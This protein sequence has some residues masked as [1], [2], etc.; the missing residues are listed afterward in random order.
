MRNSLYLHEEFLLLALKE[1]AGT[2]ATSESIEYPLATAVISELMLQKRI[3]IDEASGKKQLV[4]M[5]D[6]SRLYDPVLDEALE[7]LKNARRRASLESWIE[8]L[9][10]L[11]GLKQKTALQ[12]CRRGILRA[13]EDKILLIFKRKIYPEIDPEPERQIVERLRTVIFSDIEEI[14]PRDAIIIALAHQTHLLRRK[15]DKKDL[16]AREERIK[17]ISEGSLTAQ[18]AKEVVDAMNT[19]IFVAVIIPIIFD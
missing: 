16:K 12:L 5:V 11:K 3:E 18:A 13:D 7:K 2:V 15:F 6:S 1:D 17:K 10:N 8:R 9:A 4:D 19:V 14:P